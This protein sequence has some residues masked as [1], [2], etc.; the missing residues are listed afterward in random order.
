MNKSKLVGLSFATG[1]GF[2]VL[3][4]VWIINLIAK[5]NKAL[6]TIFIAD[7]IQKFVYGERKYPSQ[8]GRIRYNNPI[9]K[10]N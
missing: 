4:C 3:V 6:F 9:R 7:I 10:V 2:G 8:I 5:H 1:T